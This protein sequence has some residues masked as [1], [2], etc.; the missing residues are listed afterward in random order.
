[1]T[2]TT[3]QRSVHID[4]PVEK[5][6]AHVSDPENYFAAMREADPNMSG[7]ITKKPA[8]LGVDSTYEWSGRLLFVPIH[9]VVTR[10][11]YVPNQRIVDHQPS[12]D[13]TMTHTTEPD[14]SG[15]KLTMRSDVSS[16]VPFLDKVEDRMTWKGDEDLDEI[17]VAYKKAIEA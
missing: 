4:A 14:G 16:K 9:A 7:Q 8:E 5:V 13:V 11:Q 12:G 15:T 1:M 6:F 17:L 10:T 2:T 3:H